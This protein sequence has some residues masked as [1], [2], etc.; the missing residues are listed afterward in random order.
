[1]YAYVYVYVCIYACVRVFVCG[2]GAGVAGGRAVGLCRFAFTR[3][4]FLDST[5]L[6]IN[7]P[8]RLL[9]RFVDPLFIIIP[10]IRSPGFR[11]IKHPAPPPRRALGLS[12][13]GHTP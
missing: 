3:V 11:F 4:L 12:H 1:M 8:L 2:G 9:R 7:V 5:T 13:N 6:C 10:L